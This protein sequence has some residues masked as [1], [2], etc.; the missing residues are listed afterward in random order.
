MGEKLVEVAGHIEM[1]ARGRVSEL[2]PYI[3]QASKRMSTRAISDF[4]A[5]NFG[6]KLSAVSISKA[7]KNEE[8]HW[9]RFAE[10]IEPSGNTVARAHGES[11]RSLLGDENLFFSLLAHLP[12]LSGEAACDEYKVAVDFLKRRWFSLD[13]DVRDNCLGYITDDR[14]RDFIYGIG[15]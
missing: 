9:E 7:L 5:G 14:G 15:A 4:L 6:V 13:S 2:F 11:A 12:R 3:Y 1:S 8:R 10:I